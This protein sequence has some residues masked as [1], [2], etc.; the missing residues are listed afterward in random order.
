MIWGASDKA[1]TNAN[2]I[3][4]ERYVKDFTLRMLPDVSHWV[5]QEA[6]EKVN[7][8]MEAWLSGNEIPHF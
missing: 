2:T 1:L 8:I 3:G 7:A 5:Q 4:T 6:P